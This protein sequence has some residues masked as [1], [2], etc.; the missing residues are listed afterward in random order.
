[1]SKKG[2]S[3]SKSHPETKGGEG[4]HKAKRGVHR[5]SL[6]NAGSTGRFAHI[7]RVPHPNVDDREVE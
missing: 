5:E 7:A 6:P 2:G 4:Q 3:D 1:M